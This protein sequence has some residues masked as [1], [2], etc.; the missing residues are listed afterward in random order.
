MNYIIVHINVIIVKTVKRDVFKY[1]TSVTNSS[2]TQGMSEYIY[3]M[4][5]FIL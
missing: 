1:T 3:N 4:M 5:I 2:A